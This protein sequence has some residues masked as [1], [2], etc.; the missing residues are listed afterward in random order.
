M[1]TVTFNYAVFVA[2]YP[3][4]A[5]ISAPRLQSYFDIG[6][7][8]FKNDESNPALANGLPHMTNLA[9]MLTAHI[10]KLL[11]PTTAG[12]T[13]GG[14]GIGQITSAS[15]GSVSVSFADISGGNPGAAWF[16]QTTYGFLFWQST[17][18][19]RTMQY[20]ATPRMPFSGVF[21]PYYPGGGRRVY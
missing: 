15:E 11:G 21:Y 7:A 20:V 16:A 4:F 13:P 12:G 6:N 19:Y 14:G 8:F 3:E 2:I 17:A 10:A 1:S 5:P 18:Q 9:Y